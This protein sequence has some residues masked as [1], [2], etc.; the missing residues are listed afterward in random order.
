MKGLTGSAGAVAVIALGL[1][2]GANGN[3]LGQEPADIGQTG[4][5]DAGSSSANAIEGSLSRRLQRGRR[6][7]PIDDDALDPNG[8]VSAGNGIKFPRFPIMPV[9]GRIKRCLVL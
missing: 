3:P 6:R 1:F 9:Q 5:V 8:R 7:R 2:P 4:S